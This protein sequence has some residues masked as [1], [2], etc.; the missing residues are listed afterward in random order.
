VMLGPAGGREKR[1][2]SCQTEQAKE[3]RT[4]RLN[5]SVLVALHQ[6]SPL[7]RQQNTVNLGARESVRSRTASKSTL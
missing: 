7:D 6:R 4:D 5:G 3:G 1:H 2:R